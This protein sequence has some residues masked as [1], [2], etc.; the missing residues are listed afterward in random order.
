MPSPSGLVAGTSRLRA[1]PGLASRTIDRLQRRRLDRGDTAGAERLE[2]LRGWTSYV[3]L[4]RGIPALVT[5]VL[6]HR[7]LAMEIWTDWA[8]LMERAQAES[9]G[10]ASW[11]E[12]VARERVAALEWAKRSLRKAR[13]AFRG[14][15]VSLLLAELY[16]ELNVDRHF[17]TDLVAESAATGFMPGGWGNSGGE[18]SWVSQQLAALAQ[19]MLEAARQVAGTTAEGQ[20]IRDPS[21][22][23]AQLPMTPC[24]THEFSSPLPESLRSADFAAAA[25]AQ[26][27]PF[28]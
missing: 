7:G 20:Q 27:C 4:H 5:D 11:A 17:L 22:L 28:P 23:A 15:A 6:G 26:G 1:L 3:G 25:A 18:G 10:D 13:N 14:G 21:T 2:A 24:R 9:G 12:L 19:Q 8:H 16:H